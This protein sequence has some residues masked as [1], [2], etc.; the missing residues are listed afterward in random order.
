MARLTPKQKRFVGE[1][2]KDLNATQA[3]VRAGYSEKLESAAAHASR[4]LRSGKVADAIALAFEKRAE[5]TRV[6]QDWV[7]EQLKT[8]LARALQAEPVYD[9]DGET[10]L[11]Y[12]YEGNVVNR[13][14]ELIGKHLG[15][16]NRL[17]ITGGGGGPVRLT[18]EQ[19]GG[20]DDDGE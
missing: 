6:D 17:E 1:F 20:E 2:L 10:V 14:A 13:A 15:M 5:R 12:R 7:V 4:L 16:F 18:L 19:L 11:Y 3:A 9:S 8:N